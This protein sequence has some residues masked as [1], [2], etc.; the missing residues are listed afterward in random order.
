MGPLPFG[1]R[2]LTSIMSYSEELVQ[3]SRCERLS[4]YIFGHERNWS[5]PVCWVNCYLSCIPMWLPTPA[6]SPASHTTTSSY[7]LGWGEVPNHHSIL[8]LDR[9]PY[10]LPDGKEQ[11]CALGEE[12]I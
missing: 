2:R 10:I 7:T 12:K 3:L 11:P 1:R 8:W 4:G 6:Y 9:P 5:V